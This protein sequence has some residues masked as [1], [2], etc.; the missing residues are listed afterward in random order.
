MEC[1]RRGSRM[2]TPGIPRSP[3]A[4]ARARKTE[5]RACQPCY[6]QNLLV[7]LERVRAGAYDIRTVQEPLGHKDVSTTMI[8]THVEPRR[9]RGAKPAGWRRGLARLLRYRRPGASQ[10]RWSGL[11][12]A[13]FRTDPAGFRTAGYITLCRVPRPTLFLRGFTSPEAP[14]HGSEAGKRRSEARFRAFEPGSRGPERRFDGLEGGM[15]SP[16]ASLRAS[17]ARMRRR[18]GGKRTPLGRATGPE[19]SS[20]RAKNPADRSAWARDY[21]SPCRPPMRPA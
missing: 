17:E 5:A 3:S 8:Y 13:R 11:D 18:V 10:H 21:S 14:F 2:S 4:T 1:V 16:V 15:N 20:R 19:K 12:G 9:A 6:K 7:H